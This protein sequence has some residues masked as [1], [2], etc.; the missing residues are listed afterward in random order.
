M[1]WQY[2]LFP[3]ALLAQS[4]S[5]NPS[6][7]AIIIFKA[8]QRLRLSIQ[9]CFRQIFV[10]RTVDDLAIAIEPRAMAGAVP[11]L[12]SLVPP[13]ETLFEAVYVSRRDSDQ[14]YSAVRRIDA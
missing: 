3:M 5:L 12:L 4:E 13:N 1:W 9:A 10:R 6:L 11:S 8:D 2:V 14:Q 7:S